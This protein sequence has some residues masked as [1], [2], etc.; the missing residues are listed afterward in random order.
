[1]NTNKNILAKEGYLLN[2]KHNLDIINE[3]REE[4]TVSPY[5]PFN[6]N[7]KPESFP[8]YL[9]NDKY[10]CIPKY[11]GLQKFGK[12]NKN[13]EINGVST[14]IE[15]KGNLRPEQINIADI[16][17]SKMQTDDGGLLS[18]QC[19]G[20]KCLAKNTTILM[21][22]GTIKKVQHLKIGDKIMGDDSTPRT[23]LSL[24]LGKETMYKVHEPYGNGYTVNESHILSLKTNND[25]IIDI[26][27]KNYLN[28]PKE[29]HNEGLLYGYRVPII[30]PK[31]ELEI[32]PYLIGYWLCSSPFLN[33][34]ITIYNSHIFKYIIDTLKIKYKLLYLNYINSNEYEINSINKNNI[35]YD[36]LIKY[37]LIDLKYIPL[38]YK[39]NSPENQLA[40][41]AGIIDAVGYYYS[42]CYE[43]ILEN[44]KLL[45][46]IIYL[47]RS[48]G[49][50]AFKCNKSDSIF[51]TYIYGLGIENIPVLCPKNKITTNLNQNTLNYHIRLEKLKIGNYYGF[52]IDGNRRFVLG[53]FTV[54]HNTILALYIAS[55]LKVKTLVIVHKSFLLNQWLLRTKE[56]TNANVGIIQQNKVDIDGKEIVIGMLQSI[57]KDKYETDT[58]RDFGLVIFDEAHHAPS[59]YFSKALPIIACK[60]TLALSATPN[61]SDRLEKVLFWYFGDILYKA[62]SEIINNVLVKVIKYNI[63]HPHFKEY[64]QNYGQDINRPKTINKLVG[65]EKRNIF[66]ITNI[67]KILEED[68]RKLLILS[69]RVEHLTILKDLLDSQIEI[70]TSY[71]IGGLK[72]KVLDESEKAQVIFAT[73]SMASEALD[74]PTL[75][76]L[77]MVT[78]RKEVEQSVGRITRKKEHPV[79]PLILDIV[80]QLPSFVRQ[81]AYRRTFYNKKGFNVKIIEV[82]ENKI[83]Y[84]SNEVINNEIVCEEND[85]FID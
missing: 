18:L 74:I 9:E 12:P 25:N 84:E 54:T 7:I 80:D 15:F 71:Y 51:C 75:N 85:D 63:T 34:I 66:I 32:D 73:Y 20:G 68:G 41:L 46:D 40:L 42:H 57:A 30:F 1:M 23:I 61:R 2:K 27:I 5:L 39:C 81:G 53:D 56:F 43:I 50:T 24:A 47:A 29:Y 14:S 21:Y 13:K 45:D 49:F 58:F 4:L 16:V 11:Y 19:G 65:I 31:K 83:I 67:I 79:Q 82:E 78:P 72:Q 76:T 33:C 59:K 6:K 55:I 70:T 69:D 3:I 22:N 10:L 26:S 60:K 44:E 64:K 8:I 77:L 62:P 28:L 36:F 35:L 17:L 38:H 48:L 52:E 37:N